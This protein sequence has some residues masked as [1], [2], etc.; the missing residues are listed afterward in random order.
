MRYMARLTD[1][2]I[3]AA[4][5]VFEARYAL[6][7]GKGLDFL[8]NKELVLEKAGPLSGKILDIGSGR[9]MMALCLARKGYDITS[10]DNNEVMLRTTVLNLAHEGLNGKVELHKMDA[11]SL[12]FPDHSFVNI[13]M[14]EA[15]HHI[16]A[17]D[18]VFNEID[19]V[20]SPEGLFMISDLNDKGLRIIEDVHAA[21]GRKHESSLLGPEDA[22]E[23]L[24]KRGYRVKRYDNACIWMIAAR[25]T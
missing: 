24:E 21:E 2:E 1:A 4:R 5:K 8:W 12:E 6:Y 16:S 23:W 25:K 10:I 20:L 19:R 17:L 11:G 13:F 18:G 22:S 15:L 14:A 3:E 7:R 9:G